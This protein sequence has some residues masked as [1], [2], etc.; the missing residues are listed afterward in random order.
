MVITNVLN[1]ALCSTS[2]KDNFS[3]SSVLDRSY[4]SLKQNLHSVVHQHSAV[5]LPVPAFNV[6]IDSLRREK[7]SVSFSH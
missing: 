7:R 6:V 2:S 1:K 5:S 4:G 3:K